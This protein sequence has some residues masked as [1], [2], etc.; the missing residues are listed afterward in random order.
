MPT[1]KTDAAG[2]AIDFKMKSIAG[3]K[4]A[5]MTA[6]I[7]NVEVPPASITVTSSAGGRDSQPV[8]YA[9]AATGSAVTVAL[10]HGHA[11]D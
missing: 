11:V 4:Y 7:P 2:A 8:M 3:E 1:P 6:V 10:H 5:V 9:G